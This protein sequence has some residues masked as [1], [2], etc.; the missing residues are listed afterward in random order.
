MGTAADLS[1]LLLSIHSLYSF[2]FRVWFAVAGIDI[3]L[4]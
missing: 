1:M 4:S 3:Y 2:I